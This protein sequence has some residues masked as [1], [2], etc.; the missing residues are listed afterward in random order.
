M[1]LNFKYFTW[2]ANWFLLLKL[3]SN[4]HLHCSG[5][6]ITFNSVSSGKWINLAHPISKKD[7]YFYHE[8]G[9]S[10]CFICLLWNRIF[11][12]FLYSLKTEIAKKIYFFLCSLK[13]EFPVHFLK[14]F[15]N[16]LYSLKNRNSTAHSTRNL[17]FY[18]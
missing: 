9:I 14:N 6:N 7:L 3:G 12:F 18:I 15:S 17:F 11:K 4:L 1:K 10:K 16:F 13:I 5:W 2:L 8:I